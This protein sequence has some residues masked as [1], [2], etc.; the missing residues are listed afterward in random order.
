MFNNTW[1]QF[2]SYPSLKFKIFNVDSSFELLKPHLLCTVSYCIQVRS[3]ITYVEHELH[4]IWSEFQEERWRRTLENN[5]NT[6]FMEI[7]QND[8]DCTNFVQYNYNWR[9]GVNAVMEVR[10]Q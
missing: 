4:E 2:Y 9:P 3:V 8:V 10:I 7:E 1:K 5:I 6:D